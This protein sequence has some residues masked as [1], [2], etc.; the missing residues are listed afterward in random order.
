M[1]QATSPEVNVLEPIYST[2]FEV[3][4][5]S[6]ELTEEE[7]DLLSK[8]IT[9]TSFKTLTFGMYQINKVIVPI[10][11]LIKLHRAAK[12]FDVIVYIYNKEGDSI[13]T[14]IY[15]ECNIELDLSE[16]FYYN[17]EGVS[18]KKQIDVAL[19]PH[20]ILYNNKEI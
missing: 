12:R 17:Y 7:K 5:T 4:I 20:S 6:I 8:C 1:S 18:D 11:A 14:I 15:K 2:S 19:Y 9:K 16:L 3:E 10:E 13:G